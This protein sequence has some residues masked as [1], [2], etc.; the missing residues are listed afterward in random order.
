[1]E[2]KRGKIQTTAPTIRD[3]AKLAEVSPAIVSRLLNHDDALS[4]KDETRKRVYEAAKQ[5]NYRPHFIARTLRTRKSGMIGLMVVDFS[6]PFIAEVIRGIQNVISRSG[7]Y[8]FLCETLD[9][10]K[11][12]LEIIRQMYDRQVDGII[13]ATVKENDPVI[14]LLRE[15]NIKYTLATRT[16][17][18]L[19]APS[20]VFN[21]VQS[22]TAA[23][24]HLFSLGHRRIGYIL[25]H[26]HSASGKM[27]LRVYRTLL[28]Q[29]NVP[30]REEYIQKSE[31]FADMGYQAME[32]LLELEEPPTAV[33]TCNDVVALSA[34]KAIRKKGLRIPEDFSVIGYNNIDVSSLVHPAL[35]TIETPALALGEKAAEML[36]QLIED[37]PIQ[38]RYVV[39]GTQL[40]IRESTGPHS[41]WK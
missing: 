40:I 5:L 2:E 4:V 37:K 6:N 28:E 24:E 33:I 32:R 38:Q 19:E 14:D 1:M 35:T 8:C 21:S 30:Y 39:M 7:R 3:V 27:R 18:G 20:V 12:E 9:D 13:L 16:V 22:T 36:I 15:L 26:E 11:R 25:G 31:Y 29:H 34:M 17:P 23:M 41:E 10:S